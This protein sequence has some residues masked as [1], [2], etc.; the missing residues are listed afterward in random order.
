MKL[1]KQLKQNTQTLKHLK[2]SYKGKKKRL[3]QKMVQS[4]R[5]PLNS[6]KGTNQ[7][8]SIKTRYKHTNKS[9]KVVQTYH[10]KKISGINIPSKI[11]LSRVS[12]IRY[13]MMPSFHWFNRQY[14]IWGGKA[15]TIIFILIIGALATGNGG[16]VLTP[17][18]IFYSW[19]ILLVL[20][21]LF[22]YWDYFY[23]ACRMIALKI[24][25]GLT[26]G[27]G[28]RNEFVGKK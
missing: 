8:L 12:K 1:L 26:K 17:I 7:P 28:F 2:N 22:M 13:A 19:V 14:S 6:H 24:E 4:A 27:K 10:N 18:I 16:K 25:L 23:N 20:W 11:K 15:E 9:N 21:R 5:S 3:K